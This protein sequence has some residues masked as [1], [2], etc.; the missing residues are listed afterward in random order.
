MKILTLN[1]GSSSIKFDVIS[2]SVEVMQKGQDYSIVRGVIERIGTE[3]AIVRYKLPNGDGFKGEEKILDHK[4]A[5]KRIVDILTGDKPRILNSLSEIN[6]VGHRVVHGGESFSKSVIINDAVENEIIACSEFEPLHNPQN[7]SGIKVASEFFPSI[8][9]VAVFDTGFHHSIPAKAFLYA[10]PYDIYQKYKMRR[11]GFHGTS[12]R[13]VSQ[14]AIKFLGIPSENSKIITAHLGNGCSITAVSGGRSIDTSMGHTPLE[15]LM[16]GTRCGDLDPA[17]ILH[18]MNKEKLN[19][20]DADS[21]M[22]KKSGLL[23]VSGISNDL[24]EVEEAREQGNERAKLAID[25]FCYRLKKYIT[26]YA[27][28]LGGLD[29]LVFTGGIGENSSLIRELSTNGLEF[30][31]TKIDL[32]KNNANGGR[33]CK[34]DR[35]VDISAVGTDGNY[36]RVRTLVIPTNEEL[37]IARDTV[38]CIEKLL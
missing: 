13:Y 21:L 4:I 31:G 7:L 15:G 11:Y 14:Q 16:M 19:I 30:M 5:L 36:S 23:G 1:C 8:P 17:V 18:I 37:I 28:A 24:R 33:I 6:G 20:A 35:L 34:E 25:I 9:H 38:L 22:N 29:A 12:H 10:L 2:T 27:G 3:N 26:A 32:A